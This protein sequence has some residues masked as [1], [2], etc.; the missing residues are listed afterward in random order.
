MKL[1]IEHFLAKKEI[2]SLLKKMNILFTIYS[3]VDS[4]EK[5]FLIEIDKDIVSK[6]EMYNL[7]DCISFIDKDDY[8][9]FLQNRFQNTD[10]I[11]FEI[12][13]EVK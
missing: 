10:Y 8:L 6:K 3:S 2:I 13:E 5:F 1:V 12:L 4:N 11:H 7:L 9:T